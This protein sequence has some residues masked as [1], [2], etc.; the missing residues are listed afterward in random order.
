M[1]EGILSK[2]DNIYPCSD[3]G[4]GYLRK[5]FPQ[6]K[7]KVH[8]RF[9][10]TI[11]HGEK[12][13]LFNDKCY[14]IVSCSTVTKVKRLDLLINALSQI[15]TIPIKWTHYGDGILMDEIKKMAKDKLRDNIQYEFKGNVSNTELMKQ[16]QD[17]NYYVFLNV[18]SSEGIP[19]SIMEATS[20][21]IPCI[22][23]D[24]GGTKEIIS[25]KE[26]GVLLDRD[27]RT[28]IIT[29]SISKFCSMTDEEYREYRRCSRERWISKFNAKSNY[30]IYVTQLLKQI[31]GDKE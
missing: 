9:L 7:Q 21:G 19:V 18:S 25:D 2:I 6:Y 16:Y 29:A 23:T 22:A 5:R 20:F 15:K 26:N 10:G 3:H 11:D 17:K 1:R 4:T 24:A 14:E 8:T 31:S 28:E 12:E 27:A 30:E 13:Y